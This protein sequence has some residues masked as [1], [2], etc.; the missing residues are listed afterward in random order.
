MKRFSYALVLMVFVF[1][2]NIFAQSDSK[3][4]SILADASKKFRSY[5]VVKADF[6][7]SYTNRQANAR[8][9]YSGTLLLQSKFNKYKI[10]LPGQE[11]ISDGKNQ[12]TYL[13]EDKE[14]QIAEIDNSEGSLNPAQIFTIY[15]KGF[16]YVYTGDTKLNGKI[17]QQIELAPLTNRS[18]SK[19][20]L[21]VDKASKTISS[22]SVYD[23]NG[24]IYSYTIRSFVSN[25]SN[26]TASTFTFDKS[27][28][29]GV[30]IVDLR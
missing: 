8:E 23:K 15:E 14:V 6:T 18:F 29:P 2:A 11:I 3:A 12:W 27:K 16:K 5:N 28:Y 10:V 7:Y 13:K 26:V 25:V 17:V 1:T 22:L 20:K 19:I 9:S 21:S 30:E 24:N 4:K